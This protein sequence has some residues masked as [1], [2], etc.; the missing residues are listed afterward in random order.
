[1]ADPT[2]PVLDADFEVWTLAEESVETLFRLSALRVRGAT[3][4]YED[5]RTR[6]AVRE[7]TD[8]ELDWE[9]R[10]VAATRVGFEPPLPPGT[11]GSMVLPTVRSEARS[12]FVD[13][14]ADRG[15]DSIE[16]RGDERIR[17]RSGSRARVTRYRAT[18]SVDTTV[19]PVTGWVGAWY[20]A[21]DFFVVT[22]G[23]PETRLSDVLDLETDTPVLDRSS[24]E[25][26]EEFI[27]ILRSVR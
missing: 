21:G 24:G 10:F 14:L 22:G 26:R 18:A 3:R 6:T 23:H 27:D 4:R 12:T 13:R 16:R 1:M 7:V 5:G 8:G 15:L 19:V 9:W 20:D 25:Y 11:P 2:Y 17:I